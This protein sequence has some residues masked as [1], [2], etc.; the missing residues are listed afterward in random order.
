MNADT[1][2]RRSRSPGWRA[3]LMAYVLAMASLSIAQAALQ[4]VSVLD[5]LSGQCAGGGG[6]SGASII[7]AD[8]RYVLFSSAANN[9][10]LTSEGGATSSSLTPHL[11]SS[12][13]TGQKT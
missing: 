4:P 2:M 9:L 5:S 6:D 11:K 1:Y 7:S 10:V 12:F 8:G 3:G 13:V